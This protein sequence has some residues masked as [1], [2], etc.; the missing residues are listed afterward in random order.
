MTS[1]NIGGDVFTIGATRSMNLV[2]KTEKDFKELY[3]NEAFNNLDIFIKVFPYSA[4]SSKV[5]NN[6]GILQ[7]QERSILKRAIEKRLTLINDQ[8]GMFTNIPLHNIPLV[9]I[10]R[11]LKEII[12]TLSL[13]FKEAP[14]T[15]SLQ[16][17][18][19]SPDKQLEAVLRIAWFLVNPDKIPGR[20]QDDFEKLL[21]SIDMTTFGSLVQSIRDDKD[22]SDRIKELTPMNYFHRLDMQ[23]ILTKNTQNS[24]LKEARIE[25]IDDT[26]EDILKNKLKIILQTLH[27]HKYIDTIKFEDMKKRINSNPVTAL[28]NT[29]T[30]ISNNL[31]DN[32]K[33]AMN[34]LFQ[35]YRIVYNPVFDF[36]DKSL[37]PQSAQIPLDAITKILYISMYTIDKDIGKGVFKIHASPDVIDGLKLFIES[38][39]EN[40]EYF[41][42]VITTAINKLPQFMIKEQE[43]YKAYYL[44]TQQ[45]YVYEQ[46]GSLKP[47]PNIRDTINRKDPE[48]ATNESTRTKLRD[49]K[50]KQVDAISEPDF[51]KSVK[52][53]FSEDTIYLVSTRPQSE[54]GSLS[55]FNCNLYEINLEDIQDLGKPFKVPINDPTTLRYN[56]LLQDILN[57]MGT[58]INAQTI[59]LSTLIL[60][61]NRL[62]RE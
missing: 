10:K 38:I 32:V 37:K 29:I 16:L 50:Q 52:N 41:Q 13:L 1:I 39:T 61:K 33:D 18:R 57:P 44:N 26:L 54:T 3:G 20:L 53:Y 23:K 48:K 46:L 24:A 8:I 55:K 51:Y 36:L 5:K 25:I 58:S 47:F 14:P 45:L 34:P 49:L 62:N 19:K 12:D 43:K 11:N 15:S 59:A 9:K 40:P 28:S 60:F 6:I 56:L 35:Y 22:V 42:S 31:I 2:T 4:S 17:L 21:T 27:A 30:D 7:P